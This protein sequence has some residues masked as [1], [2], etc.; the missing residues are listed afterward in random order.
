MKIINLE[1]VIK[2]KTTREWV[3]ALIFALIVALVFRTWIYSPFKVPTGSMIPT[4]E[5][6]DHLFADMNHYGFVIPFTGQKIFKAEIHKGEVV[7]FPFPGNPV[8]CDGYF[9]PTF[10][11]LKSMVGGLVGAGG[12]PVCQDFIKRVVATSGDHLVIKG[13]EVTVN[14]QPE[15]GYTPYFSPREGPALVDIDVVVPEGKIFVMGDNRR[16]SHDSRYW[17]YVDKE[18]VRARAGMIFISFNPNSSGITDGI[19]W[20]R[21]GNTFN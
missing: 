20:D 12:N 8:E 15:K 7:I 21:I 6:G 10:D 16:N 11:T 5:I 14:D 4:I 9:F 3:E 13:E 19:R 1:R 18:N 17:G 2:H